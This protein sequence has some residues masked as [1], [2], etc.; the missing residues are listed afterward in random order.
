[1]ARSNSIEPLPDPRDTGLV[2]R[3]AL[4]TF[5]HGLALCRAN[6]A[7]ADAVSVASETRLIASQRQIDATLDG[8]HSPHAPA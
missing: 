7:A 1:V 3:L 8:S 6:L 4:E 2:L 5:R